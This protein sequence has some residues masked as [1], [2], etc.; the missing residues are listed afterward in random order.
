MFENEL[1]AAGIS[2]PIQLDCGRCAGTRLAGNG[3]HISCAGSFIGFVLSQ[4]AKENRNV[5]SIRSR[6]PPQYLCEGE[7][8][9]E[10]PYVVM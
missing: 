8:K 2:C 10:P 7:C 6:F 4:L 1:E 9:D 3:F 5:K